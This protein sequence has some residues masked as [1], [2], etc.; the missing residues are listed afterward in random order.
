MFHVQLIVVK[1]KFNLLFPLPDLVVGFNY[2]YD[3]V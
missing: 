2:A 3:C 1:F